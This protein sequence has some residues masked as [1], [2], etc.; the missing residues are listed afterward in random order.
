MQG[1]STYIKSKAIEL[2]KLSYSLNEI[3]Q[4]LK[5]PK[6]TLNGWLRTVIL[7]PGQ[8]ELLDTRRRDGLV[9]ARKK[10][11]IWH[12]TQK[13]NRVKEAQ[14]EAREILS[15]L[16]LSDVNIPI[17]ALSFL[18]LGEGLKNKETAMGN[19][20][21]L[22]LK[23]FIHVL[24]DIFL[25]DKNIIACELHL[26]ADQN[27]EELKQYWSKELDIPLKQFKKTSFDRR[28]QGI[29]TFNDYKGVCA[30][31]CGNV[32]IQRKLVY[33]SKTFC[34]KYLALRA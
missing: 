26:R 22:I 17:L 24:Q 7:S 11:L 33:L 6:S 20:N 12:T 31:R 19:N 16:D 18:Y 5:V 9:E 15:T 30:I 34:Q 13:E 4:L 2:R 28:T 21:P 10:A 27:E 32:A 8:K 25:V 14:D 23:F 29:Q 3:S 1:K